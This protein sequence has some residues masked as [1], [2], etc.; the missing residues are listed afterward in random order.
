LRSLARGHTALCIKV[1]AGI[2]QNGSSE[3]ARAT[4]AGILLDRGWGRAPQAHTGEGGEGAIS[5]T[6]RHITESVPGA[7]PRPVEAKVLT[8]VPRKTDGDDDVAPAK[9]PPAD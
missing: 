3:S 5:I 1:L 9:P 7:S 2:V 8:L 4:A 6:I